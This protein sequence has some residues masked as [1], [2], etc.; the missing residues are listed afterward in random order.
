MWYKKTKDQNRNLRNGV[1][2]GLPQ[3][4]LNTK[5]KHNKPGHPAIPMSDARSDEASVEIPTSND[6][7]SKMNTSTQQGSNVITPRVTGSQMDMSRQSPPVVTTT[8]DATANVTSGIARNNPSFT[9]STTEKS[10]LPQIHTRAYFPS[11]KSHSSLQVN[12]HLDADINS[13]VDSNPFATPLNTQPPENPFSPVEAVAV[14]IDQLIPETEVHNLI[15]VNEPKVSDNASASGTTGGVGAN[16][17]V[18]GAVSLPNADESVPSSTSAQQDQSAVDIDTD[19]NQRL[20]TS[21]SVPF[22]PSNSS[23]EGMQTSASVPFNPSGSMAKEQAPPPEKRRQSRVS[24]AEA[25]PTVFEAPPPM[26]EVPPAFANPLF[27]GS[28][29]KK[30]GEPSKAG[31][32]PRRMSLGAAL[33]IPPPPRVDNKM[34]LKKF[35]TLSM[36][37]LVV[38]MEVLDEHGNPHMIKHVTDSVR[39]ERILAV[40]SFLIWVITLVCCVKYIIFVLK[41]DKNGE[42]GTWAIVSLLP[43]ENEESSLWAYKKYIFILGCFGASF[44]LA[45]GII[46]PAISVLSAFEG[47]KEYSNDGLDSSGVV[48]C[49]CVILFILIMLQRFGTAKALKFYGPIM[50][51]WFLTNFGVGLYNLSMVPR[52]ASAISPHHWVL[53]VIRQP[54]EAFII[55]SQVVLAVTGVEAMY[56]DLGH[57]KT[58]PIRSS[59]LAIVYPSLIL[60]YL[61]QGAYLI[62]NPDGAIHPF[63]NSVPTPMKWYVL[64]LAT[65]A[66]SQ[67]TISGCFTLIDQ[68]ISLKV[69]PNI[70]TIHTSA[71]SAG[72]VYIPS[73]NYVML[74]GSILLILVFQESEKLANIYGIGVTGTMTVTTI[75]YML[76]MKYTWHQPNWQTGLFASVFLTIDIALL[77]TSLRKVISFGWVSI[78]MGISLFLLMYIFYVT[79]HEIEESL[80]EHLLEISELR[81]HVKSMTRTQGTVVFVSNA[82]EDVPNALRIC[83]QQLRSLPENIVCMSAISS[84]APFIADEERT[85]FRTVDAMAGIY[86]LVISYGYAERTINTVVAVERARK[87]GLRVKPDERVT[88]IVGREI[89]APSANTNVL[90]KM[91]LAAYKAIGNNTEGKVDYYNLPP[92]DTLET[93]SRQISQSSLTT[94]ISQTSTM[95]P[96]NYRANLKQDDVDNIQ[97]APTVRILRSRKSTM[98]QTSQ[99]T[100]E[101]KV[102][103]KL[104]NPIDPINK[105]PTKTASMTKTFSASSSTS[106][107]KIWDSLKRIKSEVEEEVSV[108]A[109][110]VDIE[111]MA[112]PSKRKRTKK[113]SPEPGSVTPPKD[114][115]S[116]YK[117]IKEYRMNTIAP[118]DEVGCGWLADRDKGD[119]LFRYQTL[120]ALQLSSQTKDPITAAAID[121]LKKLPAGLTP[122]SIV[123]TPDNI[124]EDILRG[125]SFHKRKT[126]Y[127]KKTA[128]ICIDTYSGDIPATADGLMELPGVGPKMAFLVDAIEQ[129]MQCAWDKNAGIGVDTHLHRIANRLKWVK[130]KET[131]PEG[132]R[133]Q[134]EGWLPKDLWAEINPLFVGFGQT[135]CTAISP[136]CKTC[137]V[138]AMCEK[139]GTTSKR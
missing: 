70:K 85:V 61:G 49:A 57:F 84:S 80:H 83:A 14:S 42:G 88:F 97:V 76:A 9:S 58:V 63:F 128:Q 135:V 69:F 89:V 71:E 7:E 6:D 19:R 12:P 87:R 98:G 102:K 73:F 132:T 31:R 101:Q 23:N 46:A 13:S 90:K 110:Q 43:M 115:E 67:A 25:A 114:W 56:A 33:C 92:T 131:D 32:G 127:L 68:A 118:V 8:V 1:A 40:L 10:E 100:T 133:K 109:E 126:I 20:P 86:R 48:A 36:G 78:L 77:I 5:K 30:K 124:L 112:T 93:N 91:R 136:F 41:A 104:E 4:Q 64:V 96:K 28:T 119:V 50:I 107:V 26:P 94:L 44:L 55:L 37:A 53:Y 138:N 111:D 95:P 123:A 74:V 2:K 113:A 66:A 139:I 62:K 34:N 82:D 129:A 54:G 16:G 51:A 121:R 79:T 47:V 59:F 17:G 130:S 72:A 45:D 137:P 11:Q 24:I 103:V 38:E 21:A 3:K 116:I 81:T 35:L 39:E 18:N 125:V 134:L 15:T 22:N 27:A 29:V 99:E 105:T 117:L 122:E 75:L 52:A 65:M 106:S 108:K 120:V 60:S